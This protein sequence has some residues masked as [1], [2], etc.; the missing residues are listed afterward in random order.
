MDV[1]SSTATNEPKNGS[2]PP[3]PDQGEH[4]DRQALVLTARV[5][6]HDR[7]GVKVP[8]DSVD[9]VIRMIRG[10]YHHHTPVVELAAHH[11]QDTGRF[12]QAKWEVGPE[13][14]RVLDGPEARR[15]AHYR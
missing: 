2:A 7:S 9:H 4:S 6:L 13:L 3:P 11:A 12:Q 1:S 10:R 5:T 15:K 8:T 14:I